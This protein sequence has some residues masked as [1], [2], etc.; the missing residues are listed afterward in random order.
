[1]TI[2]RKLQLSL[3]L[4]FAIMTATGTIIWIGYKFIDGKTDSVKTLDESRIYIQ[5]MLRGINE[6]IITEG[7]PASVEIVKKGLTGFDARHIIISKTE[8]ARIREAMSKITPQW[9]TIRE[10]TSPFLETHINSS[11]NK[12]LI[13]YGKV[14]AKTG[15]LSEEIDALSSELQ[16]DVKLNMKTVNRTISILAVLSMI[17]I[18][19]VFLKLFRSIISPI[20][21]MKFVA[22]GFSKGDLSVHM[23]E[24][25][26]DEFGS[27]AMYF[28]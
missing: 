17:G 3:F 10:G 1:M 25:K 11:D 7:T 9:E 8:N 5:M 23:D 24:S 4:I 13:A 12:L 20:K 15:S 27:L 2:K 26:Q 21:D 14:I 18:S 22:E 28:Q 6:V 16:E 19:L